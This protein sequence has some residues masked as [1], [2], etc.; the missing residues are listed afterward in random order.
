MR[1][2]LLRA[3]ILAVWMPNTH[4]EVVPRE[5][6]RPWLPFLAGCWPVD[7]ARNTSNNDKKLGSR[8]HHKK[9]LVEVAGHRMVTMAV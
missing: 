5:K 4:T 6:K 9:R 7:E 1:E 2:H 8:Q 3:G